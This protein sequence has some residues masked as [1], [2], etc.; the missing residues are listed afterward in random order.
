[1]VGEGA[2]VG[3]DGRGISVARGWRR[4]EVDGWC[5]DVGAGGRGMGRFVDG[6][7]GGGGADGDRVGRFDGGG[8]VGV[9]VG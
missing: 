4:G 2:G 3:C 6:G 1:M 9:A 7:C 5:F 8:G